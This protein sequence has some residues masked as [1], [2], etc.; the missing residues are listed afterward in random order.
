MDS[1]TQILHA[2][3]IFDA[4]SEFKSDCLDFEFLLFLEIKSESNQKFYVMDNR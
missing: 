4:D 3:I 1:S 2:G